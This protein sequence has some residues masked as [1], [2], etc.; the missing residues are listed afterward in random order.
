MRC[1]STDED[2]LARRRPPPRRPA[3]KIRRDAPR[4]WTQPLLAAASALWLVARWWSARR[5]PPSMHS[6][7]RL[8]SPKA[9]EATW[10]TD[11][12]DALLTGTASHLKEAYKAG[13]ANADVDAPS[14]PQRPPWSPRGKAPNS[15][16]RQQQVALD[17]PRR[18]PLRIEA[19]S[20]KVLDET[21]E[22]AKQARI[23]AARLQVEAAR[24]QAELT[25]R[26]A[27]RQRL[28]D[29]LK[30]HDKKAAKREAE[31]QRLLT[32]K[33]DDEK[34]FMDQSSKQYRMLEEELTQTRKAHDEILKEKEA[35][36]AQ[37]ASHQARLAEAEAQLVDTSLR[38]AVDERAVCVAIVALMTAMQLR[39]LDW[40]VRFSTLLLLLSLTPTL[41]FT[42]LGAPRVSAAPLLGDACYLIETGARRTLIPVATE[43]LFA[44]GVRAIA[45][46]AS[47]RHGQPDAFWQSQRTSLHA[48]LTSPASSD[49]SVPAHLA[50][51][52]VVAAAGWP[53][54][55]F[56]LG[57]EQYQFLML[58]LGIH[59]DSASG[60]GFPSGA[61]FQPVEA[62]HIGVAVAHSLSGPWR[63]RI[64]A[65]VLGDEWWGVGQASAVALSGTQVD[66]LL[67]RIWVE[68]F[69]WHCGASEH[70]EGVKEQ[71]GR[72]R[73][74]LI[75][76]HVAQ[77]DPR[78]GTLVEAWEAGACRSATVCGQHRRLR[79]C[80]EQPHARVVPSANGRHVLKECHEV[81]L[82]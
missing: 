13:Y 15:P 82:V 31:L 3:Q 20:S 48:A 72:C 8:A 60:P 4:D 25:Q 76:V 38:H 16:K 29:A 21:R 32:S 68:Q 57:G 27:E 79:F 58:Y 54:A 7:L 73:R 44:A 69:G 74:E 24:L 1:F 53:T 14:S 71:C 62:N 39:G 41:L 42:L 28:E 40:M 34:L 11:D 18:S 37:S 65:L 80:L 51:P 35:Y 9:I 56:G 61:P 78:G 17:A 36:A 6:S 30:K 67:D 45:A 22:E 2:K 66:G 70:G 5:R 43:T 12:T 50:D 10:E 33:G 19:A 81:L 52:D 75:V 49:L 63:K 47:M 46:A 64:G 77:A 59:Q 23:E 26:D 55:G